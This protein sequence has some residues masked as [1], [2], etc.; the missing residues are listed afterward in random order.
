MVT[1]LHDAHIHVSL[2]TIL[3]A[4]TE[5][6]QPA[7]SKGSQS[8]TKHSVSTSCKLVVLI[9]YLNVADFKKAC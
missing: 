1:H 4:Q 3:T 5:R 7:P 8:Q 6:H 2:K 9:T